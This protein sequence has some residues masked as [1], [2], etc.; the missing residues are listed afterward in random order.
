MATLVTTVVAATIAITAAL[1]AAT[2][3]A[4][5]T[6]YFD[7]YHDAFLYWNFLCDLNWNTDLVGA[8]LFFRNAVIKS[9]R[10]LLFFFL[11]NHDR[12][13]N[14]LG[15]CFWYTFANLIL[16]STSLSSTFLYLHGSSSLFWDTLRDTVCAS[17][18]F[19][20]ALLYLH[21]ASSL[22]WNTLRDA[23]CASSLF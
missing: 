21:S 8:G 3:V 17:S 10:I 16:T 12:V 14:F 13:G 5:V 15:H 22:F 19:W 20:T 18:L 23:V 2:V 9:Y 6:R 11:W 4:T 7:L 1:A